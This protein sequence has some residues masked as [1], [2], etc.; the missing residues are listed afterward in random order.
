MNDVHVGLNEAQSKVLRG[1]CAFPLISSGELAPILGLVFSTVSRHLARLEELGLVDSAV[2]GAEFPAARRYRLTPDAARRFLEPEVYFHLTRNLNTLACFLPGLEQFYRLVVRLPQLTNVGPF[3]SFDWRL[4]DGVGA[5]AHY[6]H[7]TVA[8][9]WSGP[10]QSKR[11][12]TKRLV[13]LGNAASTMG[14][15]PALLCVV[16]SDL[17]QVHQAENALRDF[18]IADGALL[19]CASDGRMYRGLLVTGRTS[20]NRLRCNPLLGAAIYGAPAQRPRM[21]T[22]VR[23]GDDASLV[24]RLLALLEQFQGLQATAMRRALG[25]KWDTVHAKLQRLRDDGMVV[26]RDGHHFLSDD[27]LS[28]AARRDRVHRSKPLHRFGLRSD[29]LPAVARYLEHDAAAFGIV[30]LFQ[31]AGFPVAGGWRGEDYSGGRN[32]IA[33]DAMIYMGAGSSGGED[34]YY[35][36][37]ERRANSAGAVGRKLRGYI[38]RGAKNKPLPVLMAARSDSMAAEFRRQ[39][40]AAGYPLWAASIPSIRVDDPPTVWGHRTVWLDPA[41]RP[42]IFLPA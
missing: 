12:F 3:H 32:A 21:M 5:M 23:S 42:A 15:W 27:A 22:D 35:L 31:R 10:W 37:Y 13:D 14:G 26:E 24:Y 11:A 20:N 4:R 34:W 2:M 6:K 1:V 28:I 30:S 8:F 33:P 40:G 41:G 39:A 25:S 38:A 18:G 16:A 17:W 19:V 29:G 36:E 9:F 7:G